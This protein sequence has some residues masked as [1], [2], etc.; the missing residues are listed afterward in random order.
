[1]KPIQR[2]ED[3]RATIAGVDIDIIEQGSGAPILFL[4]PGTGLLQADAFIGELSKIGR[5]IAPVLPG[6]GA[7]DLPRSFAR[8][9]DLAQY[10]LALL[11]DLDLFD[12]TIVGSSFGGWV[13]AE[14][15]IRST[16]RISHLVLIGPLGI[17]AGEPE[18]REIA[19]VWGLT[20]PKLLQLQF[21]DPA[22]GE[23]AFHDM[24][25]AQLE[26]VVRS[27]EAEALY[28][29]EPYMQNPVLR[30]WLHAIDVPTLIVR[31]A[32]D[33]FV[34]AENTRAFVEAIS[35]SVFCEI[36]NAG[37][38]PHIEQPSATGEL[39]SGFVARQAEKIAQTA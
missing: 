37:H 30:R 10:V 36:A 11:K 7:S 32:A 8:T 26:G 33:K 9:D 29:W 6:F 20:R 23:V 18:T 2:N 38:F 1:M 34:V 31:G 13:A 22:K 25:Q 14:T 19:D 5:V 27:Q 21:S 24:E 15:A 35:G 39:I 4:H 3:G 17:K 28:G 16:E 12:V